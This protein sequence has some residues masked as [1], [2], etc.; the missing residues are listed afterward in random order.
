VRI[1]GH[2]WYWM[3]LKAYAVCYLSVA[4]LLTLID[5]LSSFDQFTRQANSAGDLFCVMG[6]YYL[7]R[8]QLYISDLCGLI[9][10]VALFLTA[11]RIRRLGMLRT[12]EY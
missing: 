2:P 8:Q 6:R 4:G 12:G 7:V 5:S 10:V 3:F 9:A 11:I 1:P